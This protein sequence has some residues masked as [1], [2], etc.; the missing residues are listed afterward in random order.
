MPPS[1]HVNFVLW[2]QIHLFF[3]V[4]AFQTYE[5]D[6]LP[7]S[8]YHFLEAF[9]SLDKVTHFLKSYSYDVVLLPSPS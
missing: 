5:V 2:S 7:L 6:N 4:T 8:L 1:T 3:Y 9:S